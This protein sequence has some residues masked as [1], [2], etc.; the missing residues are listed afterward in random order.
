M[1]VFFMFAPI[2]KYRLMQLIEINPNEYMVWWWYYIES[3]HSRNNAGLSWKH[4]WCYSLSE[5]TTFI[6]LPSSL[7]LLEQFP[8]S[9]DWVGLL[10]QVNSR[11]PENKVPPRWV[12]RIPSGSSIQGKQAQWAKSSKTTQ[13]PN[14]H[15]QS[16]VTTHLQPNS[17]YNQKA[18]CVGLLAL[19]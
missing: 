6:L 1:Y 9:H 7:L 13:H 15:A 8:G 19:I 16:R 18:Q 3:V 14:I 17:K 12:G 10:G 5:N 2:V 4:A 11:L